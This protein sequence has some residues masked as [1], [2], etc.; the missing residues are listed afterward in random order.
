MHPLL[1]APSAVFDR[2][3]AVW[4][5]PRTRRAVATV[6]LAVFVLALGGVEA[7]RQGLLPPRWAALLSG[8]H[9]RALE[10]TF[11]VLLAAELADLVLGLAR[12]VSG[13][14]ASQFEVLVLILVRRSFKELTR[15]Q[16]PLGWAT[17]GPVVPAILYD[18]IGAL[19]V[20]AALAVYLRADHHLPFTDDADQVAS[21]AAG[22]KIVAL[23]LL[24]ALAALAAWDLI[25]LL[26]RGHGFAFFEVFYTLLIFA[27]VFVVLL[28]L[29]YTSSFPVV[30][31]YFGFAVATVL[32]R[33][34]L[35]AP[36]LYAAAL[37]LF[38]VLY[39][40]AL[41]RACRFYP[42][43]PPVHTRR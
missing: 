41:A 24:A 21:F 39:A 34:A 16:E 4:T 36:P 13:A 40:L 11:T 3:E 17:V 35:T 37:G 28:S 26:E 14:V 12:S 2:V 7:T 5:A 22:K 18:A 25:T 10:I 38:A 42:G 33:L 27:D 30:F 23:A 1:G 9:F 20:F 8:N 19:A 29:R 43:E 32:V 15:V 6:L 31:R